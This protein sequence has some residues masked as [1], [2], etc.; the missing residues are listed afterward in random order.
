MSGAYPAGPAG[1]E[2]PIRDPMPRPGVRERLA[3][4]SA[5]PPPLVYLV[6]ILVG[7][8]LGR[9]WPLS[10]WPG[11]PGR[12]LGGLCLLA[13]AVVAGLAIWEC[14]R[15][16]TSI[17]PDAPSTAIVRTGPYRWSRNPMYLGLAALQAGAGLWLDNAWV[18]L[19]LIPALVV[20]NAVITAEERYL[21]ARFGAP[22]RE[23][24]RAVRRWL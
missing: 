13:S 23:Y 5:V 1:A 17:R 18:V 22:Y 4:R 24:K 8:L 21:Q 14:W 20:M 12:R 10:L 2:P 16:R 9:R 15:A 11:P 3:G 7:L 19:M 6:A